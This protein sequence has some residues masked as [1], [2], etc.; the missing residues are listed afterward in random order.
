M[1]LS[2]REQLCVGAGLLVG[3][4]LIVL[5]GKAK[6]ASPCVKAQ[7]LV[8]ASDRLCSKLADQAA[9]ANCNGLEGAQS[10]QCRSMVLMLAK[11]G[12]REAIGY[13]MLK[14]EASERCL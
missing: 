5:A 14:A 8:E 4:V 3:M 10:N 12:C 2:R 7:A 13:P 6:L 9:Q 11:E 1:T